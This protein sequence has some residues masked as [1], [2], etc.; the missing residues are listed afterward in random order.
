MSII[1][2]NRPRPK[3]SFHA[4]ADPFVSQGGLPF[5]DVLTAEDI[6]GAFA[7]AGALFGQND[8]F[9]TPIVLWAF[10]AQVPRD[11]KG[12]ACASAVAIDQAQDVE[13][14]VVQGVAGGLAVVL[15]G[16]GRVVVDGDLQQLVD[17]P[18]PPDV[19]GEDLIGAVAGFD[20]ALPALSEAEGAVVVVVVRGVPVGRVGDRLADPPTESIIADLSDL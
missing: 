16:V 20:H 5:A 19:L 2:S 15:V 8:I 4:V 17:V 12:A 10:L 14:G 13:V 11:G 3:S 6:E 9:S 18:G 1:E 7:A